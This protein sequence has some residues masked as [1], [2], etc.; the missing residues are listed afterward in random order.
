ML[1]IL[2]DEQISPDVAVAAR[3]L[4]RG[5]QITT[6]F[7]WEDGH[8]VGSPDGEILREAACQKMTLLSFD[9]RTIPALLRTWGEQGTPHGGLIFVDEKSIPQSD[10]GG[11]A[12]GLYKLWKFQG[13]ADWTNRCFFL[14][15]VR[16]Q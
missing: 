1:H 10:I 9:L 7:E 2:T 4:C 6:L 3:K 13:D 15:Q 8:F 16:K 12:R 5:I 11:M 14:Q